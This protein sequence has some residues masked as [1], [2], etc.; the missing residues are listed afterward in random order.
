MQDVASMN[1][2]SKSTF[3]TQAAETH[4]VFCDNSA[5]HKERYPK[6][7]FGQSMFITSILAY[8]LNS[9]KLIHLKLIFG[10]PD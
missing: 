5:Y 4:K 2:L 7:G 6:L 3:C 1:H 8:R 10:E 9:W